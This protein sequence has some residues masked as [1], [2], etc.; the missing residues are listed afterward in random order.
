M[1]IFPFAAALFAAALPL[2]A[3]DTPFLN[4]DEKAAKP[5]VA[6]T[7]KLLE[8]RD[9]ARTNRENTP[10]G[11]QAALV[12]KPGTV[13]EWAPSPDRTRI[14]GGADLADAFLSPDE[15]LLVLLEKT[16]GK[17]GPNATRV[18]CWNLLNSRIVNAFLIPER[19]LA[20]AM[21]I[22]GETRFIAIQRAQ[23]ELDQFDRLIAIDLRDGTVRE[24]SQPFNGAI[25]SFAVGADRTCA[26]VEGDEN[27]LLI[28]HR[29]FGAVPKFIRTLVPEPRLLLS[30]AGGTLAVYGKGRMELFNTAGGAGTPE[31]LSSRELPA[32]FQ[33]VSG[34]LPSESGDPL[35]LADAD[36]KALLL[37]NGLTRPLAK[38][39]SGV[40][41][42]RVSDGKLFLG[43]E[44]KESISLYQLPNETTPL[45]TVSP[46]GLRPHS[47]G[48]NFRLFALSGSGEPELILLDGQANLIRL[49]VQPRRWK[50]EMLFTAP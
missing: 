9:P 30:P 35:I 32:G 19:K 38:R 42:C 47:R 40:A 1:R 27:I 45:A 39:F 8:L 44:P 29:E 14:T 11:A 7:G 17:E 16:G 50:K 22:P 25:R 46:G 37:S 13:Y 36:G 4:T 43:I 31:L 21:P 34:M 24:E 49:T 2:C 18:L 15:T 5:A 26:T 28:P 23:K 3:L 41:A 12:A 6:E 48:R 33:P 20:A 10:P